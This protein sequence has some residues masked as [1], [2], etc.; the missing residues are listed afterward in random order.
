MPIGAMHFLDT[1]ERWPLCIERS[2]ALLSCDDKAKVD[3]GEPGAVLSTGVRGKKRLIPMT[4]SLEAL[5][6]DVS[7][8]GTCFSV[9][10]FLK[11]ESLKVFINKKRHS[12]IQ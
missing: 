8:K 11:H 10:L 3:F 9:F 2:V 5:D 7:K 4:S 12:V 1:Y 6:H